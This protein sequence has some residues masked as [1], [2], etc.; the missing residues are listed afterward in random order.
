[1]AD[2]NQVIVI[3]AGISGLSCAYRL[4]Q[5]GLPVT[6]LEASDRVGG[7]V[8][9]YENNGFLF[10][11]GPQSFQGTEIILELI[12]QLGI[13]NELQTADP[14]APRYV[15]LRGRLRKIPMTPQALLTSTL[16]SPASRWKVLSEP[17]RRTRP[18]GSE[19]TIGDFVRRKFGHEILEYLV[20]PFVS[21]VYAGDPEK[22]SLRA[23]F[24]DLEEWEKKY[25]SVLR[26]AMKSRPSKGNRSGPPPL[27]SFRRGVATLTSTLGEKLG[28]SLHT[29]VSV[30]AVNRSGRAEEN[31]YQVRV[32]Q[33]GRSEAI[34][35]RAVVIATPAYVAARLIS[36]VSEPLGRALS[37]IAYAAVA[38]VAAGYS[39]KLTGDALDGFGFLVPRS[40]E[41]HTLGTVWN[42]SLY[43]GRAPAGMITMT[44][45]A[46]GATDPEI[47]E[48]SEEEIA[49]IVVDENARVLEI[50]A[51]PTISAVWRHP[52]ALPQYNLGHG[53]IVEAIREVVR[54]N[55]G[56]YFSGNYLEGPSLGKCVA[57][58]MQTAEA[59]REYVKP[60]A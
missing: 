57:Q 41:L 21:G 37:G 52:K 7:L 38:V 22:L 44:S 16:L 34:L 4:Q 29:G 60:G 19:E 48:K 35:A 15:L 18:P 23:A 13:E 10:E 3:G 12:K 24:P 42:S 59:V 28:E 8:G 25:G 40:E 11:S 58:G 9:S 1:M 31:S 2:P 39:G 49:S 32:S 30:G 51:G 53:Y 55:P 26:G 45:F 6:L 17:F 33:D 20:A 56:L 50:A 5:L 43:P 27:C 46:G 36:P 14:A 54:E 47:V